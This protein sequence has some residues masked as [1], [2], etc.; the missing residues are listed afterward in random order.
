MRGCRVCGSEDGVKHYP[1]QRMHLCKSCLE[2]TPPKISKQEFDAKYWS[3]VK[4]G[5]VGEGMKREFYED[6]LTS[7]H[8]FEEYVYK[9]TEEPE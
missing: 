8:T 3:D 7:K 9:T 5:H 2:G 1:D 4:Y 6:Y